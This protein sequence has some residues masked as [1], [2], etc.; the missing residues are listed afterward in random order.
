[1]PVVSK[2]S[3]RKLTAI[4]EP[5]GAGFVITCPELDLATQ[6][7]TEEDAF[8]DLVSMVIDYAEQYKENFELFSKSPNRS[9]HLPYIKS[10]EEFNYDNV[11]GLFF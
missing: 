1:M 8:E 6:G 4:I 7:K 2:I 10:I 3:N 9:A 11:R 5:S